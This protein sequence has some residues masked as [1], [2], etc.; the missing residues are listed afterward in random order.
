MMIYIFQIVVIAIL[1]LFTNISQSLL[2]LLKKEML[3]EFY[4]VC[5]E[6]IQTYT[7]KNINRIT[8]DSTAEEDSLEDLIL[9]LRLMQHLLAKNM[10]FDTGKS[11]QQTFRKEEWNLFAI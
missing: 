4:T 8:L 1:K 3:P 11:G 5:R 9:L 2:L 10:L 6:I 7:S